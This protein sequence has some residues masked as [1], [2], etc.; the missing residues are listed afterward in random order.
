MWMEMMF[1]LHTLAIMT[2]WIVFHLLS[3][4]NGKVQWGVWDQVM[5]ARHCRAQMWK[6]P[7]FLYHLSWPIQVKDFENCSY[8]HCKIVAK[9]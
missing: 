5:G 2:L 1:A 3:E 8:T 7:K 4:E 6:K 9:F